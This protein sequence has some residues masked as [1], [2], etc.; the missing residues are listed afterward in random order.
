MKYLWFPKH[1]TFSPDTFG[2][3]V[4]AATCPDQRRMRR[5]NRTEREI[6]LKAQK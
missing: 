4:P 3:V 5:L 1:V 2:L 6:Y